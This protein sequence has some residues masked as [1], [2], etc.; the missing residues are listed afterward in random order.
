MQKYQEDSLG[1]QLSAGE[2]RQRQEAIKAE[3]RQFEEEFYAELRQ[4]GFRINNATQFHPSLFQFDARIIPVFEK[5][6]ERAETLTAY[7]HIGAFS[8]FISFMLNCLA[9]QK[10]KDATAF[11]IEHYKYALTNTAPWAIRLGYAH[12]IR[13]I[14]D[15]RYMDDY[16]CFLSDE[17]LDPTC[18]NIIGLFGQFQVV[19]AEDLLINL[20]DHR[21]GP[22]GKDRK[23]SYYGLGAHLWISLASMTALGKIKSKKA[24]PYIKEYL[25]PET[26]I[27]R[28]DPK[29]CRESDYHYSLELAEKTARKAIDSIGLE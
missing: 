27:E 10:M 1:K 26:K 4:L 3:A 11:L 18:G 29:Y 28:P 24:L 7:T 9:H 17:Y 6:L 20:I 21:D 16:Y 22:K 15:K 8:N 23:Q 19:E 12:A 2:E 25:Q 5:Y 14:E 13:K